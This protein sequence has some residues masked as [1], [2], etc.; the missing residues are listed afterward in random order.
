MASKSV[1]CLMGPT[2]SGKT[3]LAIELVQQLPLAIVSVDSAMVYREMNIGTAKPTANILQQAPHQ[4]IDIRDPSENY[5]AGAFR[6]DAITAIET[7]LEKKQ[8]P[9]LVGGTMLYFHVLQQ[10]MAS[11]PKANPEIRQRLQKELEQQGL[12]KL[13]HRL[14]T[15]DPTSAQRIHPNDPQRLL[16]ALEVA[17]ITGKTLTELQHAQNNKLPY[18]FINIGLMPNDRTYLHQQIEKRFQNMLKQG[19]IEEVQNLF[20]RGDLH[21]NLPSIRTVG[22][23]QIWHYLTG[24]LNDKEMQEQAIIATRQLAKRQITWLRSWKNIFY[25]DCENQKANFTK[26]HKIIKSVSKW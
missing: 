11:L 18:Q 8:L 23:R 22:Y 14:Q 20:K 5:S 9:L 16:R 7:I 4:L 19:F 3:N 1:I 21:E 15:L 2:A 10:G 26:L 12:K 13:H 24:K 17:E 6:E 25:F